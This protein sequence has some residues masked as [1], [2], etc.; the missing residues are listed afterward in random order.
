MKIFLIFFLFFFHFSINAQEIQIIELHK[1]TTL[2]DL[3]DEVEEIDDETK[4]SLANQEEALRALNSDIVYVSEQG[5]KYNKQ[6]RLA[7]IELDQLNHRFLTDG[8]YLVASP[9]FS[10]NSLKIAYLSYINQNNPSVY[11]LDIETGQQEIIGEFPGMT[12]APRFSPDGKKIVM[13]YSDPDIGNAEIY[14]IDL[15]TRVLKR[16]TNNSSID[17][18]PS[19][20]PSGNQIVFNSNRNGTRQLFITD[21]EG[22]NTKKISK[23]E[24]RY[25]SPVW[26]PEGDKIAFIKQEGVSFYLG[27]MDT[28]GG[29]ERMLARS[30]YIDSPTWS[31][32]GNYL[33]YYKTERTSNDGSGGQ[34]NLYFIDLTGINEHKL[35]TPLEGSQPDLQTNKRV[36]TKQY[37]NIKLTPFEKP[38]F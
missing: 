12:F 11:I 2:D 32:N 17:I 10:P 8:S 3:V 34:S 37:F 33:M 22:G 9:R 36:S 4:Y 5:P 26:S 7:I 24:G 21:S 6:T 20:S 19:Y 15:E 28:N 29:N 27:I 1:N 18:S 30:F 16:I 35:I 31:P 13:S 38:T 14:T 23:Q 25:Y